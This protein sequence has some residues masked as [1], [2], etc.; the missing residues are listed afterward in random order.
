MGLAKGKVK[1]LKP[2]FGFILFV[3]VTIL[4]DTIKLATNF[5][6]LLYKTRNNDTNRLGG[7]PMQKQMTQK[8]ETF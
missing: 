2:L 7:M 1:I 3:F 8:S 5:V 4:R 6:H